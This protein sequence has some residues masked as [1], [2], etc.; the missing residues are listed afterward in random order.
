MNPKKIARLIAAGM[1]VAILICAVATAG[2]TS[3]QSQQPKTGEEKPRKPP[4]ADRLRIVVTG[5]E[6]NQ[7][8]EGASVYISYV[9]EHKL[10]KDKKIEMNV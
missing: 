4:A 3:L 1:F 6:K 2:K 9:Q 10:K 7:P 5:G 8:V